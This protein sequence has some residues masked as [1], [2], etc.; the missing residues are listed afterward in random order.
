MGNSMKPHDKTGRNTG[1]T[2]IELMIVLVVLAIL[3]AIAYPSYTDYVRKGRR[4]DAKAALLELAQQVERAYTVTNVYTGITLDS[5]VTSRVSAYYTITF[6][7][8]AAQSYTL[9]AVP[10]SGQSGDVCGTLTVSHTGARTPSTAGCW[11]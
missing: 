4:A 8:Q 6:A 10:T 3:A 11:N 7:A 1:F 9:Q 2:L 5:G